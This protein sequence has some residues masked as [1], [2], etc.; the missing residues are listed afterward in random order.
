MFPGNYRKKKRK[1]AYEYMES[2]RC[3]KFVAEE[4]KKKWDENFGKN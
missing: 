3:V 2:K 1:R 4:S